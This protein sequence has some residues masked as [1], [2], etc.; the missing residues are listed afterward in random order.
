MEAQLRR[1][2]GPVTDLLVWVQCFATFASTLAMAYPDTIAEL[3]A[4]LSTIVR[5]HR[6]YEGPSWVLYDRA[7][8]RRA[9]ATKDMN[10]SVVNTSLF[11]L[12]FGGRAR[13]RAICQVCL[14]EQHATDAC[15]KRVFAFWAITVLFH[16][17]PGG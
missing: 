17:T 2:K 16:G 13:R 8:R 1:Q 9:E 5:C 12:C 4:Y 15:P 14:S 7:F 11:N 6:D 10:W 3:M